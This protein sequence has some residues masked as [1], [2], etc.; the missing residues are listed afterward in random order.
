MM[1]LVHNSWQTLRSILV[2][3]PRVD[4]CTPQQRDLHGCNSR[5]VS[6]VSRQRRT[7]SVKRWLQILLWCRDCQRMLV[8][9]RK[10]GSDHLLDCDVSL[11][12]DEIR[13]DQAGCEFHLLE[14]DRYARKAERSVQEPS[15]KEAGQIFAGLGK[16]AWRKTAMHPFSSL[17]GRI[18]KPPWT[19]GPNFGYLECGYSQSCVHC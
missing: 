13:A 19:E 3:S 9:T 10:L 15:I 7:V 14:M 16:V 11:T 4:A 6:L 17:Q 8:D 2:L 5:D 1:K 12:A 18:W